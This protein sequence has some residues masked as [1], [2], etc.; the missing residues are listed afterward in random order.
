MTL[1]ECNIVYYI[2][3]DILIFDIEQFI[4]DI[5]REKCLR[6]RIRYQSTISNHYVRY[7]RDET[8]ISTTLFVTFDIDEFSPSISSKVS[9][10]IEHIRYRYTISNV[11]NVDI[12]HAFD[13]EAFD[14]E[15][16]IR[17]RTSDTRYRGA[18]DP[19]VIMI[20]RHGVTRKSDSESESRRRSR[21]GHP[22]SQ[23]TAPVP[24][25]PRRSAAGS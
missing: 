24:R 2:D 10:D 3:Y 22:P 23:L 19:D 5:E 7:R 1:G 17:Y 13:I 14:I 11:E 20:R 12:E 18:K 25:R 21:H 16:Y 8:S 9:F 15:C 6:Y 4:L